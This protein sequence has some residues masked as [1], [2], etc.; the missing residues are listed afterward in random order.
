MKICISCQNFSI[1]NE[2]EDWS[3]LT[4]GDSFEFK[5]WKNKWCFDRFKTTEEEFEK[6]MAT[7]ENCEFFNQRKPPAPPKKHIPL[8]YRKTNVK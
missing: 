6:M 2:T 5:C 4:P 8:R 1:Q 7:A 3:K